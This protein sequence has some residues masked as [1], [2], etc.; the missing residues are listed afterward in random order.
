MSGEIS[1]VAGG[2]AGHLLAG[3][4][5]AVPGGER[6]RLQRNAK[7]ES[8]LSQLVQQYHGGGIAAAQ[9]EARRRGVDLEGQRLRVIVEAQDGQRAESAEAA[10]A[11]GGEVEAAYGDLVQV[12]TPLAALEFLANEESVQFVRQPLRAVPAVTGQGIGLI[13]AGAW[14]K[15]G[16][17]GSGV[18]VAVLDGGF[19]SYESLLGTELPGSVVAHS[20]RADGDISGGGIDHGTAVAEIVYEIA[21]GASLYL[22]NFDTEV[23]LGNC[24]DWLVGQGVQIVNFSVGY[25]VSGPGDGSGTINDIVN[26]AT[27]AGILWAA[28]A[29][30]F[31]DSHWWG[32]W[33]DADADQLLNF[34][35]ADDTNSLFLYSGEFLVVELKWNDPWQASCNDYDLGVFDSGFTLI[36]SSE[37]A[38]DCFSAPPTELLQFYAPYDDVYHIAIARYAATGTS[39]FHLYAPVAPEPPE[40]VTPARSLAQPADNPSVLTVG[41]VPWSSPNTIEPFSSQGP[42]DDS[43]TKPDVVAPDRVDTATYGPSGFPG[44]SASA[45]HIAGAAALVKQ[46]L[47]CY[48]RSQIQSFLESRAVGLGT[49]GKDNVYGSGRLNLGAVP[50]SDGDGQGDA[51]D[52]D[53]DNDTILDGAD[54]CPLAA[55]LTQADTD[56][57][58]KG[59]A[60]DGGFTLNGDF[61]GDG[62]TDYAVWR[63]S[64]GTWYV[65]G[66]ARVQWGVSGDIPVPGDFNGDGKTD[67]AVWRPSNGTWYVKGNAKVQW[68]VSGDIPVPGDYN[69]DG[70]TDFAVW[71]PSTGMWH[72]RNIAK[73]QWGVS[74]DRPAPGDYNGDGRTDFA[75]WRPSNGTWYVKGIVKVQWG[76]AGDIPVPGDYNGDGRTD[77]AV[78]RPSNGIWYVKGIVKVQWGVFGDIPVP[79]DYNGDGRTDFAVWRP[80]N[81]T[82][83]VKGIVKV[84]WGVAGDIPLGAR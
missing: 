71:R 13:N 22:V 14:Q 39:K 35:G 34:S 53:D 36:A 55:N 42:T 38:Q 46:L 9:E 51:C 47:P 77:F 80:S 19:Q 30:N 48:S 24:V 78:W 1:T 61:N 66:I 17:D 21:P 41:A 68:G 11:L 10:R 29:G 37:T 83:Y 72:V 40:Y 50:D 76:V 44:T 54:N 23:E 67:Y 16:V 25:A 6:G 64:N 81:G 18:K 57:D 63:P 26:T 2:G 3:S 62:K 28:A 31:A 60:C 12:L 33:S 73:Q 74:T 82:W 84:Q 79:G 56:G 7:L 65:K 45:P 49:A 15:A 27:S 75:V 69:G 20:C 4:P 32:N 70:R 43:R 59:D 8:Q 58:G 5:Q 52:P